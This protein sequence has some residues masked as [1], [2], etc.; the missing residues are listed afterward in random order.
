[1]RINPIQQG[2]ITSGLDSSGVSS[3]GS[4]R[5]RIGARAGFLV[6]ASAV[7]PVFLLLAAWK[8]SSQRYR[9]WLLTSFVTMYGATIAIRYDPTGQGSDGVRHLLLVYDHYVGMSFAQFL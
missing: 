6:L 4:K 7:A 1:M 8:T 9:H 3:T 2:R 5:Y